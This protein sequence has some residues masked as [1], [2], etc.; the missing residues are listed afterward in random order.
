MNFKEWKEDLEFR[1]NAY[2]VANTKKEQASE[3]KLLAAR[4]D[5]YTLESKLEPAV[6]KPGDRVEMKESEYTPGVWRVEI[7][8]ELDQAFAGA[9]A[10]TRALNFLNET[11]RINGWSS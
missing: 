9:N 1:L 3:T 8:G 10:Y 2:L 5:S 11:F 4:N 6:L 7:N